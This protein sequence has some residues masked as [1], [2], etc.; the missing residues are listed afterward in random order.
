MKKILITLLVVLM[1]MTGCSKVLKGNVNDILN[2]ILFV[3]NNLSNTFVTG[4]SLYLP[5]GVRLLDKA[6]DNLVMEYDKTIF[7][8]YVDTIAYYYKTSNTFKEDNNHFY[9]SKISYSGKSGYVD[10]IKEND[11][12][13]VV[14]MYNYA[15]VETYV[16]EENLNDSLL[17]LSSILSS[18]KYNDV[19]IES[20]ISKDGN[21]YQEEKFNIFASN[22]ENDNFLK[23][24]SEYGTYK[25]EIVINNDDDVIDIDDVIE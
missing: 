23:Y 18:I 14:M 11:K 17:V 7:Y 10:I 20:Y 22:K 25:E 2:T 1:L 6:D 8:L 3:D 12:Y 13:F 9:S 5:K 4:F 16:K 15:K 21:T 19:V 24:E